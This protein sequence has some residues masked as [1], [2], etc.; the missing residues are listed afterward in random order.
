MPLCIATQKRWLAALNGKIHIVFDRAGL[1]DVQGS[2]SY[3]ET[4]TP[5]NLLTGDVGLDVG[6]RITIN[7]DSSS[8]DQIILDLAHE[9]GHAIGFNPTG[10]DAHGHFTD[11]TK[12]KEAEGSY[13]PKLLYDA[14]FF[15][16]IVKFLFHD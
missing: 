3:S 10:I 9:L 6:Q 2:S 8:P 1:T 11:I 14:Y 15:E 7:L 4:A 16:T 13:G 5:K 12:Y